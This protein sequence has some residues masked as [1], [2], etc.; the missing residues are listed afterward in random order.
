MS[1]PYGQPDPV[2]W[3]EFDGRRWTVDPPNPPDNPLRRGTARYEHVRR[4]GSYGTPS[5]RV[6]EA[7]RALVRRLSRAR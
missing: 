7:C 3:T 5:W 4:F 2:D 1:E 6:L